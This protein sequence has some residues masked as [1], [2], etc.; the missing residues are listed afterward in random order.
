MQKRDRM[1]HVVGP[2]GWLEVNFT[3]PEVN[4]T[5]PVG[6]YVF[7][8]AAESYGGPLV[9][10][11]PMGASGAFKPAP[12]FEELPEFVCFT[13]M[14]A[15]PLPQYRAMDV[16]KHAKTLSPALTS[17]CMVY[18]AGKA[19][20][21]QKFM[22]LRLGPRRYILILWPDSLAAAPLAQMAHRLY[23]LCR[24]PEC[25]LSPLFALADPLKYPDNAAAV[26]RAIYMYASPKDVQFS[27][28]LPI[29]NYIDCSGT[30]F[31]SPSYEQSFARAALDILSN[32]EKLRILTKLV[33]DRSKETRREGFK[34]GLWTLDPDAM[35]G[36]IWAQIEDAV[37]RKDA[38]QIRDLLQYVNGPPDKGQFTTIATAALAYFAHMIPTP[39]LL[40]QD[41]LRLTV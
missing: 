17:V 9:N 16:G 28:W 22:E 20:R 32:E 33:Y 13:L 21:Q 12:P 31:T 34:L 26:V 40:G 37:K 35:P 25:D 19:Y 3:G 36:D 29:C 15:V 2:L 6:D 10:I 41:L 1:G 24:Q 27:R 8:T 38:A 11:T 23:I 14:P 4:F 39:I 7:G 18:Y 30:I 5:A